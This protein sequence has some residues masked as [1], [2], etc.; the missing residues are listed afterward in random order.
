MFL[1]Y[2]RRELGKRRKQTSLIA[3]GLAVAI[4]LVVVVA[5]VSNGIKSAQASALSGLYGV[6]TDLTVTKT[7]VFDPTKMGQRFEVGADASKQSGDKQSFSKSRLEVQRGSSTL[8]SEEVAKAAAVEGVK[9]SVATL[10]LNSMTFSGELPVFTQSTTGGSSAGT[11][12]SAIGDGQSTSGGDQTM[13]APPTGGA[14]GAGG[15]AFDLN[16]FSVEGVPVEVVEVGPLA[17]TT[18]TSGRV[19][20]AA[21]AQAKVAVIDATYATSSSLKVGDKVSIADTE[22]E[23]IG[24]VES[25]SASATTPSNVYIPIGVAQSLSDN[26]DAFTTVYVSADSSTVI[27]A[28][29]A[30]LTA[31]LPEVTVSSQ[32]DLASTVSGSLATAS[33]LVS[34][35]GGWL[36]AVVLLA[37]FATSILFT[38]SGVNRRTREFGTLKAIGWRSRRIVGQVMGESLVTGFIGGALGLGLGAAVIYAINAFGPTVSASVSRGGFFGGPGGQGAPNSDSS[39]GSQMSQMPGGFGGG[40]S[41]SEMHLALNASI[42][43]WMIAA[44]LG[45]AILGGLLAGVFGGLRAAKLS[46][47]QALR[48]LS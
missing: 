40:Q 20:Q 46:P 7:E 45:F 33:S 47:A 36:A 31:A 38:T 27:D 14:D 11:D 17:N 44:A 19:F 22:F 21:D 13:P 29:K 2:L 37:A 10:K 9:A 26:A 15:S 42:E 12:G 8:T 4:A 28:T 3:S 39:T 24:I 18:V 43:P 25:S 1:T 32:S 23:I 30:K 5:G 6:G 41:A 35:M 16:S 48:S 34:D